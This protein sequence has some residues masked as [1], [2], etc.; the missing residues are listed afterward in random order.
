MNGVGHAWV[1]KSRMLMARVIVTYAPLWSITSSLYGGVYHCNQPT[2][3]LKQRKRLKITLLRPRKSASCPGDRQ[4]NWLACQLCLWRHSGMMSSSSLFC[5]RIFSLFLF[6]FLFFCLF[7]SSFTPLI[8]RRRCCCVSAAHTSRSMTS[9]YV[10]CCVCVT[11]G[12]G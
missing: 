5:C 9:R 8:N 12:V 6:S 3:L 1:H 10:R 4:A 7:V 11:S 2:R